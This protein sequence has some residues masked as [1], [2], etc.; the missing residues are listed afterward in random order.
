MRNV[1]EKKLSRGHLARLAERL[2]YRFIRQEDGTITVFSLIMFIL[3]IGVGGIAIDIMRTETQRVQIQS[4]ADRA[5]IAAAALSQTLPPEE[6]VQSYFDA[7][8]LS[9]VRLN[10]EV[11]QAVNFRNVSIQAEMEI[12]TIF[13]NLFGVRVMTTP[14]VASAEERVRNVE[15]SLV[16]DVS[17]SMLE[18]GRLDDLR[19]AARSFVTT[20]LEANN[21]PTG[22]Q[23][24]SI[25]LVPYHGNVNLGTRLASVFDLTDEHNYSNCAR[26]Y[27]NEFGR[28]DDFS[29]TAIDPFVPLQRMG[30]F[31]DT[32][33]FWDQHEPVSQP[34]C[35]TDDYAAIVPWSNNEAELHQA[36]DDIAPL[37]NLHFTAIDAGV[38]WGLGLLDPA[39]QPAVEALRQNDLVDGDFQGRPV[40]Y[41]TF[42]TLKVLVVMTDGQNTRQRDLHD[43]FRS[44]P[45]PFWRDADD[46]DISVY[47][48]EY[49]LYWHE[50]HDV[51]RTD[52]D[53]G[54]DGNTR[55]LDWSEVFNYIPARELEEDL[56]FEDAWLVG[57]PTNS[58]ANRFRERTV[59]DAGRQYR[60]SRMINTFAPFNGDEADTRLLQLCNLAHRQT[61]NVLVFGISF[62]A[63]ERGRELM[64]TCATDDVFYY[65]TQDGDGDI[66]Q[67]LGT[68]ADTISSLRLTQ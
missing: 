47:Y 57:S 65:D 28:G 36:I 16:L 43:D 42:D 22:D 58:G 24:V 12:Q 67:V 54:G 44:G 56:F 13:M 38:K 59:R 6:V 53:D 62:D 55:N 40:A 34:F 51:W 10:I 27:R 20:M 52:A 41:N 35:A 68:I 17:G 14:G 29:T 66:N 33:E 48:E 64:Q 46:G 15:I 32:S 19:P 63:P 5:A 23:L 18:D 3:M 60:F 25:S 21:N 30:H 39:A 7:A 31:D 49:D 50:D 4:T 2:P 1:F 9:D 61:H 45:S 8:G 11:E 37:A 26:F